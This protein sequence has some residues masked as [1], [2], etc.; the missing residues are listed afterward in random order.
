VQV[1]ISEAVN[2]MVHLC[3]CSDTFNDNNTNYKCDR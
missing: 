2:K 1:I 3:W